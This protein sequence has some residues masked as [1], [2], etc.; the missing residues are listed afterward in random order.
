MHQFEI[1]RACGSDRISGHYAMLIK[2]YGNDSFDR[3]YSTGDCIGTQTAV[4]SGN[5]DPLH[6]STSFVERQN[7]TMRMSMHRF[8]RQCILEKGR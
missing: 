7:L 5:P 4:M 1:Y 3:R 6:I 2:I 8:T